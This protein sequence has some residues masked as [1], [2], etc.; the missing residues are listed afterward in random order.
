MSSN[1]L[2]V[3]GIFLLVLFAMALIF[4]I[5]MQRRRGGTKTISTPSPDWMDSLSQ[6]VASSGE[7]LASSISEEIEELVHARMR[8]NPALKDLKVDFGT[9]MDGTLEIWLGDE[10]FLDLDEIPD[11]RIR[12]IIQEA[13]EAYNKGLA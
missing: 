13:V 5:L 10:R 4:G 11:E 3:V 6:P 8:A 7:R 2:I 9:A 1:P 12:S